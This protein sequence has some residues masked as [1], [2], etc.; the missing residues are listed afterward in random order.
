MSLLASR[1]LPLF[2]SRVLIT[3]PRNY[4]SRL[5]SEIIRHG[6]L[7]ITMPT[8]ETCWLNS[9]EHLDAIL[10]RLTEFDWLIFTSRNG[11]EAVVARMQSLDIPLTHLN[12]CCLSAIGK[13][14]ERLSE[15]GLEASLIPI[16]PSPQGIVNQLG[17][18]PQISDRSIVAT[19]PQVVGIPE[20]DVVANFIVGL[21]QLSRNVIRVEAYQTRCLEA[22]IYAVELDLLKAGKIDAIAFSSTAEIEAFLNTIETPDDC[23]HCLIACFGP[24]TANNATK[25]GFR[26][27]IVATDYSSFT[28]FV[29]AIAS[30][31]KQR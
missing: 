28:G 20:P 7:P 25:L 23:Q 31:I 27:D 11:I 18:I 5:A 19:V 3:A 10:T 4:A 29:R 30:Q 1:Q 17:K 2:G 6:G 22:N 14:A 21:Q 15:L 16:E 13:D 24:Y 26:V 8:V 9:Y 12:H